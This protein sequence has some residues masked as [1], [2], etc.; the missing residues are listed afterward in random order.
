MA[1]DVSGTRDVAALAFNVLISTCSIFRK[2][3]VFN[4]L[5]WPLP[6][7]L[8][9]AALVQYVLGILFWVTLNLVQTNPLHHAILTGGTAT[10]LSWLSYTLLTNKGFRRP[11]RQQWAGLAF[12]LLSESLVVVQVNFVVA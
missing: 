12:F 8:L 5:A 7:F 1:I 11:T 2:A 4:L 3:F 10:T 9:V 6:P